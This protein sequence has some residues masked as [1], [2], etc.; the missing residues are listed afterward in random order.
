[1]YIYIYIYY[2]TIDDVCVCVCVC[3]CADWVNRGDSTFCS[4]SLSFARLSL[5]LV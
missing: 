1:M 4:I 3:V 5:C 2:V